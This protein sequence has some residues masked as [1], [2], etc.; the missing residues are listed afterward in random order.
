MEAKML[1][2]IVGLLL[3]LFGA[4]ALAGG[5]ADKFRH[6]FV[7]GDSLSDQGNLFSATSALADTFN[8]PPVPASDHYYR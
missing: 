5:P 4:S 8:L 3:M 6:M 7:L 2:T 1:R